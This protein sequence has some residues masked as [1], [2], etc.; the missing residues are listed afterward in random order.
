MQHDVS[1]RYNMQYAK[2]PNV[3]ACNMK[4]FVT[5]KHAM[6]PNVQA[7]NMQCFLTLKHAICNV[8]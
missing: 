5:F 3:Q 7:R 6:F 4:R 1:E 8:S 2:F